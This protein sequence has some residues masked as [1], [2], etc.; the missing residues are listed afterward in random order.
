MDNSSDIKNLSH[1]KEEIPEELELAKEWWASHG[2]A[3][4]AA[5]VALLAVVLGSRWWTS[6][7]EKRENA[8]MTA[9]QEAA[10]PDALERV[11]ADNDSRHATA[12]A[13]LRLG[14]VQYAAGNYELAKAAY[15]DFVA[16]EPRHPLL[17]NASYG[18]A[19]CAEALGD[20]VESTRLFREFCEDFPDS[21]L[22]PLARIGVA[23]G[24]IL[25]GT[26]ESRREGKAMLDLFLTEHAG[27]PWAIAADEIIR[28][29]NRL[30]VP[31]KP[32]ESSDIASFLAGGDSAEAPAEPVVEIAAEAPAAEAPA[33]A[34]AAA[35]PEGGEK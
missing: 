18:L 26:E 32:A 28:A 3:V 15:A 2:N 34:P 30:S 19:Q 31:E 11:I 16:S 14:A 1:A 23:R 29:H 12:I 6:R 25:Q 10:T 24:L 17:D 20:V 9:L 35:N 33:E 21:T 4:T 27:E 8:A 13:R 7:V 5:L 22:A